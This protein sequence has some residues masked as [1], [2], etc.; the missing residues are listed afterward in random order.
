M[1]SD[2]V[3]K[4]IGDWAD[5]TSPVEIKEKRIPIDIVG[6]ILDEDDGELFSED[7]KNPDADYIF[8]KED[9][10]KCTAEPVSGIH[11]LKVWPEY[12]QEVWIGNKTFELRK[13]DR[14]YQVG[15]TLILKEWCPKNSEYT[16]RQYKRGITYILKDAEMFGLQK[17]YVVLGLGS[18][19]QF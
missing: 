18:H 6:Q 9:A 5:A 13:N 15:N 11:E 16:G 8:I 14:D 12:F 10:E 3:L 7:F 1:D 19:W 4:R 2:N 17:D